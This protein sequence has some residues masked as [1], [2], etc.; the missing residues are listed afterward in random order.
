MWR[1]AFAVAGFGRQLGGG[2][3]MRSCMARGRTRTMQLSVVWPP[4]FRQ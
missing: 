4:N 2:R 1:L 3:C